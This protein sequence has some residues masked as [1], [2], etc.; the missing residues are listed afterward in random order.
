MILTCFALLQIYK[1]TKDWGSWDKISRLALILNFNIIIIIKYKCINT[2][3]VYF[4]Y[5]GKRETCQNHLCFPI[6]LLL[7]SNKAAVAVELFSLRVY[8]W[9]WALSP[10]LNIN[11]IFSCWNITILVM[12]TSWD[13]EFL[14]A[15]D[16]A[17][18]SVIIPTLCSLISLV[19]ELCTHQAQ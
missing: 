19:S 18:F 2:N 3:I 7:V 6:H 17:R 16:P 4:I 13:V 10:R 5:L 8:S 15:Q 1:I 11:P 12:Q 9:P 14:V